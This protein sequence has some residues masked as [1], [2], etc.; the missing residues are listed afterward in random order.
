MQTLQC[1]HRHVRDAAVVIRLIRNIQAFGDPRLAIIPV[2]DAGEI[3]QARKV[4]G[5]AD[6]RLVIAVIRVVQEFIG[7]P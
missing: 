4:L 1:F 2:R 5:I 3:R 7:G 6:Q